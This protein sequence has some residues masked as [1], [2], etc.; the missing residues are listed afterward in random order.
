MGN[1]A[2]RVTLIVVAAVVALLIVLDRV[3]VYVAERIAADTIQSS[4]HLDS[5]PNVDIAGFPFLNQLATGRYDKVTITADDVPVGRPTRPLQLSRVQVVLHALT[6][7]RDFHNLHA[8]RAEAT[9]LITYDELSR[10][11]GVQL[12]YAGDG[13]IRASKTVTVAG[14]TVAAAVTARPRIVDGAL[15]FADPAVDKPGVFRAAGAAALR[16]LFDVTIP[17]HRLRFGVRVRSVEAEADGV[18]IVLTGRDL[19]YS[20]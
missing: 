12:S 20:R 14:E 11:L 13:R 7:S 16:H 1:R 5:R 8:A 3:A 4:Q 19:S 2:V 15:T 10:N 18:T 9:G 6:A 17:L